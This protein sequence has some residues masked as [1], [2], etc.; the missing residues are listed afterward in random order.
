[1]PR[2]F[3]PP[4]HF[5]L[6][7]LL[8]VI[9]IIAVLAS[10]LLPAL[11]RA[12]SLS[13]RSACQNKEKQIA[14]AYHMYA[15]DFDDRIPFYV[16]DWTHNAYNTTPPCDMVVVIQAGYLPKAKGFASNPNKEVFRYCPSDSASQSN[17]SFSGY[18]VFVPDN[19]ASKPQLT[20]VGPKYSLASKKYDNWDAFVA[21][22]FQY[23]TPAGSNP[24]NGEGV[25]IANRDGSVRWLP[26]PDI[27]WPN[28]SWNT[29]LGFSPNYNRWSKFWR[30]A[31]GY[32][33]N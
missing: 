17:W 6:I 5:T 31:S 9:A 14:T 26:R 23:E 13:V 32:N 4:R 3:L 20:R 10:M 16:H 33:P 27:G 28:Y 8:V 15:D 21:C 11:S 1:M 12:R 7:E 18:A 25:N 22:V 19:Y 30:L 29:G 2:E 24:H